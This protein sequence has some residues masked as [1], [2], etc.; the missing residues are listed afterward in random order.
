MGQGTLETTALASGPASSALGAV[1]TV[2]TVA[3]TAVS[4]D[5]ESLTPLKTPASI[6]RA[7]GRTTNARPRLEPKTVA[8]SVAAARVAPE[9]PGYG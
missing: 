3:T 2:S 7:C 9:A 5:P 6:M 8:A 1:K 4:E